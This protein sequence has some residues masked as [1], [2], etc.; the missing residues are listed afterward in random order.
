MAVPSIISV[1][2]DTGSTVGHTMVEIIGNDFREPTPQVPDPQT[3]ITPA[4][5]DSVKVEF[6]GVEALEVF[7]IS[8]GK[9]LAI[10][11][12]HAEA[13]DGSNNLIG[14][15]VVVSNIDDNGD[16]ISGEVA[17]ASQ[18]FTYRYTSL[19]ESRQALTRLVRQVIQE[20]RNY[21]HP[22]TVLTIHTD[23]DDATSDQLNITSIAKLP[24]IVLQGPALTE[25]R[26]YSPN[27]TVE[28]STTEEFSII[29]EP[30]VVD[31]SFDVLILSNSTIE[32]INLIEIATKHLHYNKFL[33]FQMDPNDESTAGTL[34][35]DFSP[36]G[37]FVWD[38]SPNMSN[39]RRAKGSFL[40]RGFCFPGPVI[41]KGTQVGEA[42]INTGTT[43]LDEVEL[44][45][46]Q[47]GDSY[48]IGP[49]PG[50]C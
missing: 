29:R 2:P 8:Q 22:N 42:I 44:I 37:D 16:V 31:I 40:L 43:P 15:D 19:Y 13:V 17:T 7:W 23:F 18:A 26:F 20:W 39:I 12:P 32:L 24:S 5:P 34:E 6:G 27:E 49:S 47:I 48:L 46:E 4:A 45:I 9:L 14:V 33:T 50:D 25:N 36:A 35:V 21:V 30:R 10:A 3:N 28:T 1:T 38:S 11:P 41:G